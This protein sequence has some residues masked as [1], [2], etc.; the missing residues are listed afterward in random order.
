MLLVGVSCGLLWS[1]VP[2]FLWRTVPMFLWRHWEQ[3]CWNIQSGQL[4]TLC[5]FQLEY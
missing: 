1:T 5:R 4:V 2:T 3:N